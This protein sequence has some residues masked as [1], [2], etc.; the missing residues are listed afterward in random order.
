[1]LD[2]KV[3]IKSIHRLKRDKLVFFPISLFEMPIGIDILE[4]NPYFTH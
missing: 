2:S 3:H 4:E 1:M